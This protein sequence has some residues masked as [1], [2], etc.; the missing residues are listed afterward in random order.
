MMKQ[1]DR[2]FR[3]VLVLGGGNALGA[4]QAGLYEA[5]QQR[6]RE[7][8]WI[9][10]AS[11]GGLNAAIIA[12]NPP[13]ARIEK[14]AR[15]WQPASSAPAAAGMFGTPLESWRRT[16][17]VIQTLL[18]GRGG[19]FG[20]IGSARLF[21][22][23]D[24]TAQF[25]A[26]YGTEPMAETLRE[27]IDFERLKA[28]VPPITL[29]AVDVETGDDA[30]FDSRD[31]AI[32]PDHIRASG[33]LLAAFPA[34]EIQ[35]RRYADAGL[36]ANLP[37]DPV[38]GGAHDRP[39]LCIAADLLPLG[40]RVPT[41]VGEA[42]GRMQDIMFAAQSR[43]SID[44]WKAEYASR[45]EPPSVTLLRMAYSDQEREVAGKA[46]DFS[47][48]SARQRWDA[49]H[50]DMTRLLDALDRGEVPTGAPG[51][52]VIDGN[53]DLPAPVADATLSPDA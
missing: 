30:V 35:G 14:L 24:P 20:S 46:M 29:T 25:P 5:L 1:D 37:L 44:R 31:V 11:I 28:C 36:S 50:R 18:L 27:L 38:L 2:P 48:L 39:I 34:V 53:G 8:D 26:L 47:P 33:A 42:I 52:T 22:M 15:F 21:G 16:A 13:E 6:G 12:G 19:M 41:E 7:P 10:G 4:Y 17:E 32:K 3:I 9:V 49:G 40:G 51:L 23:I 45:P 43:R